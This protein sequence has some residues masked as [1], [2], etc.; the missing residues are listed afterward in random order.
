L[1]RY[2][3]HVGWRTAGAFERYAAAHP[4]AVG[5]AVAA[6]NE[7]SDADR[8][9]E[10]TLLPVGGLSNLADGSSQLKQPGARASIASLVLF[11]RNPYTYPVFRPR[12]SA[13][14]L[15]ALLSEPLDS[16]TISTRLVSFYSGLNLLRELLT[17]H[18]LPVESNLDVQGILWVLQYKKVL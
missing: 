17:H 10:L 11:S 12:I 3:Q 14:P 18:G 1:R 16:R 6:L 2:S 7:P 8:F 13:A 9:W 15:Q 4:A 5:R